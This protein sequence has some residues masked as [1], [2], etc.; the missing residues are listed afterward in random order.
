MVQYV[1]RVCVQV[2]ILENNTTLMKYSLTLLVLCTS[3]RLAAQ[4]YDKGAVSRL[5]EEQSYTAVLELAAGT[6]EPDQYLL[7]AAGY[8]AY[9]NGLSDR[10]AEYYKRVLEL[11]SNSIVANLYSGLIRRQQ[12]RYDAARPFFERLSSLRPGQAKYLKYLADC[13][14]GQSKADSALLYLGKAYQYA[15]SDLSIAQAYAEALYAEKRYAGVDSVVAAGLLVDSAQ[16][17]LLSIGVKAA[18]QQKMFPVAIRLARKLT[19]PGLST[20]VYT[21][22][23]FGALASLQLKDY[24]ECLQFTGY[25][26]REGNQS[27]QVLYYSAKAY[28]GL[29]EYELANNLLEQ[30][31][32]LAVSDNTEAY[33]VELGENL[34]Q[35]KQ[36]GKA[37]RH[38]DTARFLFGGNTILYRKALAYEAANQKEKA[39]KAYL[40]FIRMSDK[41]DTAAVGFAKKR[42]ESL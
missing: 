7:Q 36:Y 15:G 41:K 34:E 4:S 35:L 22:V 10:A 31:L 40:E 38:Y 26:M 14:S 16:I 28:S 17:G 30:C 19:V 9:Q 20:S 39:K 8:A 33:Y 2:L 21:P 11:D 25:L 23:M 18:Y 3:L 29:K 42:L 12:R 24:K 32:E 27:E 37:Q 13:Y 5:L 6:S 1:R